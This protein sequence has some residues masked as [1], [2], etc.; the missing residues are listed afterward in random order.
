MAA[1]TDAATM[2]Q[3]VGGDLRGRRAGT[4]RL[5]LVTFCCLATA[6]VAGATAITVATR[7][8]TAG[9]RAAAAAAAVADRWRS[10]P[11]GKIFPARLSYG[12]D[13]LTSETAMRIAISR[14]D[15]CATTID[16]SL[17][18]L[19]IRDRCSAGLRAT[20]LDQLQGIVYTIGILV[21]PNSRDAMSFAVSLHVADERLIALRALA[22]PG[23][24]SGRFSD[25]AREV[26]TVRRG[27]PFVVLTVAGYADGRAAAAT[28]E[29]RTEIFQP[30]AQ[31][32]AEVI[33][34]L[35]APMTVN[36]ASRLWSC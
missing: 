10:W 28:A 27:G 5:V 17:R 3:P 14:Q 35:A 6:T 11:A 25:V 24:A 20:Y 15:A 7:A 33:G 19:T 18:A 26:G 16:A 9:E 30:A 13:L 4:R 12:T 32:A 34:P 21:F 22:L 1:A 8:P 36:C 31:L 23:T 29:R 2:P